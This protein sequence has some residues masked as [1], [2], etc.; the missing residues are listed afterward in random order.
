MSKLAPVASSRYGTIH[1]ASYPQH[2]FV[3][4]SLFRIWH[5]PRPSPSTPIILY[6]PSGLPQP[7]VSK[8]HSGQKP[9]SGLALSAH[10]TVIHVGYRLSRTDTHPKPVH[11]VLAAYDWVRKNLLPPADTSSNPS[12]G[13]CGE[14]AGGSLAAMLALTECQTSKRGIVAAALGNP[15][16]DWS[17]PL[18]FEGSDGSNKDFSREIRRLRHRAFPQSDHHYDPFASPLLFF[19]TPPYEL[20]DPAYGTLLPSPAPSQ[21]TVSQSDTPDLVP[22]RRSHRRYPPVE[23]NLRLPIT[24]IDLGL[25]NPL[26]QQGV[27]LVQLMQRSVD[28]YEYESAGREVRR[29]GRAQRAEVIEREGNGL[30][31]EKELGDVGAWLGDALRART[32]VDC[33]RY[34]ELLTV[35]AGKQWL[36]RRVAVA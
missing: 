34:V 15:I 21:S 4:I 5:P 19:R 33:S 9:F 22:K 16:V 30:W 6:L 18:P 8:P 28:L 23:S 24:R 25:T 13:V 27:E 29:P 2:F 32:E 31:G 1:I 36:I 14:L 3:L 35:G 26:R 12:I 20:P 7:I 11:D 17:S 10:A